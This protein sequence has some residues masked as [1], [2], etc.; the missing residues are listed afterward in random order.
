MSFAHHTIERIWQRQ[1]I[2][3]KISQVALTPFSLA[4]SL[5]VRARNRGYDL[6]LLPTLHASVSVI[7]IGN[8][9]VG[10]TGKTPLTLWLAQALQLRGTAVGIIT[11]GYGGTATGPTLVGKNG[12]PLAT[13]AEVGDEAVMLARR[14]PGVVIS[15][16][17]RVAA[18]LFGR[19]HF[20]LDVVIL[21]DG[22]QHRRLHREVDVLLISAQRAENN[23]LLPAGPFREPLASMHRAHAIVLSKKTVSQ[24]QTPLPLSIG[25][26][27]YAAC[28]RQS[29]IPVFHA[30]LVPTALVQIV[31]GQWH[32]QPLST[33][34]GKRVMA[35]TGV[36]NPQPFYHTLQEQGA[37]LARVVEFPDHHSYTLSEWQKLVA[38][39]DLFDVLVTT[40]KDL[41]KLEHLTPIIDRLRAVRVQF[42]L[43]PAEAFLTVIEQRLRI[44]KID[45]TDNGRTVSHQS[46]HRSAC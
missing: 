3:S 34:S 10:G 28:N 29:P 16:R 42:Q 40:E 5:V 35:I 45:R 8:L 15:G 6:G 19:Q 25:N 43:E 31:H 20:A 17:D 4:F 2:W 9:T 37:E 32:E 41:V 39:S 12:S 21:D 23:W 27:Q 22:F 24:S 11:R 1:S 36:A 38:E 46:S 33:L 44:R 26:T 13:P 18:A 30:E 7:S 14:F